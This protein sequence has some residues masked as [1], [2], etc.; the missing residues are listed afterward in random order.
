MSDLDKISSVFN[1]KIDSVKSK[2]DL[3]NIKTEFFGKNGQITQQFK[4][5]GSLNPEKR[6]EFASNLNKI[7]DDLTHQLEKKNL[8]MLADGISNTNSRLDTLESL[9]IAID[10]RLTEKENN[11]LR[12]IIKISGILIAGL[13]GSLATVIWYFL[14]NSII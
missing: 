10:N 5:L 6:K 8:E 4:S 2:E 3:Q 1:A 12:S 14:T 9:I 11:A 7:K 13:L